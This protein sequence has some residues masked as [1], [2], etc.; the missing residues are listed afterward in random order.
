MYFGVWNVNIARRVELIAAA[1]AARSLQTPCSVAKQSQGI[2]HACLRVHAC[3][4]GFC[5]HLAHSISH[6][7][8]GD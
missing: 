4:V 1:L 2:M 6:I 5:G 7:S 3:V 8:S